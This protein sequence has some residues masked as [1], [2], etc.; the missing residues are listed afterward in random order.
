MG[1]SAQVQRAQADALFLR[2]GIVRARRAEQTRS[3][4]LRPLAAAVAD[5]ACLTMAAIAS[6]LQLDPDFA[7]S[8]AMAQCAL[9][10]TRR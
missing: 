9:R 7:F 3:R 4:R 1:V 6:A 8:D 10:A 2:R 5:A